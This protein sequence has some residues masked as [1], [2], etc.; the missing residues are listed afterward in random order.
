MTQAKKPAQRRPAP[1]TAKSAEPIGKA[2]KYPVP[3]ATQPEEV[4]TVVLRV[5]K[6]AVQLRLVPAVNAVMSILT[7]AFGP[8]GWCCRR[9]YCDG[10]LYCAV[11]V[12]NP[13]NGDYAYRDAAASDL[14]A[15]NLTAMKEST[16]L[17]NAASMWQVCKDIADLPV[18]MLRG[19]QVTILPVLDDKERVTGYRLQSRLLTDKFQR[20]EA[21]RIQM[22]QFVDQEDKKIVWE[23][24]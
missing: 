18:I 3:R 4:N 9:Y 20:D 6:D 12:Y 2:V 11:G 17:I 16:S 24:P 23:N 7:E 19:D 1:A 21:G 5:A 15:K 8:L 13:Q 14:P 22:V 10:S